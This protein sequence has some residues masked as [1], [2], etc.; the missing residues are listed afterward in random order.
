ML[1]T[2][3]PKG[4]Q[5]ISL[6]STLARS[7]VFLVDSP[8]GTR[9]LGPGGLVGDSGQL[10]VNAADGKEG[11]TWRGRSGDG[12]DGY[13]SVKNK[14]GADIVQLYVDEYDNGVVGARSGKGEGQ[15][16]RPGP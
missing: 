9:L 10:H 12:R 4:T 11:V 14:T 16:L 1:R 15:T 6:T 2:Y 7:G 8:K 5:L 3:S 13:L